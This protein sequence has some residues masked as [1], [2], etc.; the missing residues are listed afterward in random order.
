MVQ[1]GTDIGEPAQ[2]DLN[3]A[4]SIDLRACILYS[5][6]TV[7]PSN[8]VSFKKT[9]ETDESGQ[10]ETTV[11]TYEQTSFDTDGDWL[12]D[13]YEIWDFKT[14]WNEKKADGTYNQDSDGDGLPDGYE[15]FTMGTNPMIASTIDEKGEEVNSDGDDWS[16]LNW[17]RLQR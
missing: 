1:K 12:E 6:G 14:K 15:V 3:G 10:D 17:N 13:G 16:D 7:R 4:K 5:D 11:V 2:V 8:I 9:E